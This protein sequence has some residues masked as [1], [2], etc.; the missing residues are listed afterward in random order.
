MLVACTDREVFPDLSLTTVELN[1]GRTAREAM[2]W[3]LDIVEG[4]A[5]ARS[6]I[7]IPLRL[8]PRETT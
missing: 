1:P 2:D 7:E 3:L 5:A 8:V 4:R 6:N